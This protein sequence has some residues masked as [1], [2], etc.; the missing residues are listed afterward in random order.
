MLGLQIVGTSPDIVGRPDDQIGYIASEE[1][2]ARLTSPRSAHSP[3][4]HK[5]GSNSQTHV[6]SPLRKTSFPVDP[7]SKEDFD[8]SRASDSTNRQTSEHALESE[9][10]DE[11]VIH[12]DPLD[13]RI[14]KITGGGFET[15]DLGPYGG[16]TDAEGGWIDETGYGVPILASDEVA[17]EP[18]FEHLQPAV[19]PSQ[20]R[21]SGGAEMPYYHTSH[22]MSRSSSAANSRPSSRPGSIHGGTHGFPG[23]T[24]YISHEERE[25]THTPLEDVDE[26]EPLFPEDAK[27]TDKSL[28]ANL[29]KNRPDIKRRFPSQDI[30]E[31][32]PNSLQLQAEVTTPEPAEE[33]PASVTGTK[34]APT[35]ERPEVEGAR[36][37]EVSE[38]DKSQLIPKE[39][40]WAKSH[41]KPHLIDFSRPGMKQRFPSRDIWEDTPDSAQLETTVGDEE[42]SLPQDAGTEAGAVVQTAGRPDDGK[43]IGEQPRDGATAGVAAISKPSIPPRPTRTKHTTPSQDASNQP[44]IPPR[45]Q[46]V[47]AVPPAEIPPLVKP[48]FKPDEK[49]TSPSELRKVPSIPERPKSQIP[50]RPAKVTP[51]DVDSLPSLSK[52]TSNS[53]LGSEGDAATDAK[54]TYTLPPAPKPKPALPS[55]P[56]GGKIAALKAGFLSDLD[57]RL[58]IGPQAPAK[59]QEKAVAEEAKEEEK[60]PL[61]DARKGRARGP[62]RRKPGASSPPEE[63]AAA[64]MASGHKFAI[65]DPW[66]LW[67]IPDEG[68]GRL[69]A[70][71]A[72]KSMAIVKKEEPATTSVDVSPEVSEAKASEEAVLEKMRSDIPT[73]NPTEPLL[74]KDPE[75]EPSEAHPAEKAIPEI[76]PVAEP[77]KATIETTSTSDSPAVAA[78]KSELTEPTEPALGPTKAKAKPEASVQTG[79][80]HITL[81]SGSP[82]AVKTTAYDDGT[83]HKEGDNVVVQD[84][85]HESAANE[86]MPDRESTVEKA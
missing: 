36:K 41:F 16:N 71:H 73:E 44:S 80:R 83:A 46:R 76:K 5:I 51:R 81:D 29:F 25:D 82:E 72:L 8:K 6:E 67:H 7:L 52:A 86:E 30:W 59:S 68:D 15:E 53:S 62:A 64:P 31:D 28:H 54:G 18:G 49:Q 9:A 84:A 26:Y 33:Q 24:K 12:I 13:V 48:L 55:R 58:A 23:L 17:K 70:V 37:G 60:A 85:E 77:P 10:E 2:V 50:A 40:R 42:Q 21:Q 22:R 35:F 3:Y 19:S 57:K 4:I 75:I 39:E 61:S 65:A 38:E 63:V 1:Y 32:T 69:D 74:P 47:H 43:I 14:N 56:V 34:S 27:K 79:E 11:D 78:T 20:E 66:T 45:P